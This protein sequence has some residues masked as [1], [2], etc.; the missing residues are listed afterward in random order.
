MVFAAMGT[1]IQNVVLRKDV[2][3]MVL[4]LVL[5]DLNVLLVAR[6][7]FYQA[8]AQAHIM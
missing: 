8:Y 7:S 6:N 3:R 2:V 1:A 4:E 5:R